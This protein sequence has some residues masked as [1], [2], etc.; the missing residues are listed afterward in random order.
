MKKLIL[1]LALCSSPALADFGP[2]P[3]RL[4]VAYE[5]DVPANP[6]RGLPVAVT[7][8]L[9]GGAA[10]GAMAVAVSEKGEQALGIV[11]KVT[12]L[13]PGDSALKGAFDLTIGLVHER[14]VSGIAPADIAAVNYITVYEIDH[15][16]AEV[17]L[18]RLFEGKKQ[19]GGTLL[20]NGQGT[21]CLPKK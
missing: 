2:M 19:L 15:P 7:I 13:Y 18:F 12:N 11:S 14:D 21:R 1:A 10:D 6:G 9:Q 16:T 5:C 3:S 17:K 8:Q 20:M 4:P